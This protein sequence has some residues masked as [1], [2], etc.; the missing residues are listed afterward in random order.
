[1]F[2]TN[3]SED[4]QPIVSEQDNLWIRLQNKKQISVTEY[5][6]LFVS[7][8]NLHTSLKNKVTVN[9]IVRQK[10]TNKTDEPYKYKKNLTRSKQNNLKGRKRSLGAF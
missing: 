3:V 9:F 7:Y 4:L 10:A 6:V 1:M 2:N 5:L 8:L